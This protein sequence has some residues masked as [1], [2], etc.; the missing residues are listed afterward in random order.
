[1]LVQ[2]SFRVEGKERYARVVIH[3]YGAG[4][5]FDVKQVYVDDSILYPSFQE[6]HYIEATRVAVDDSETAWIYTR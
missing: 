2:V 6:K 3:Y 1:M 4:A 5:M